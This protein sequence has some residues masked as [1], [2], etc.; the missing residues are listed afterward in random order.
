MN[1]EKIIDLFHA[2]DEQAIQACMDTYGSY[3]RAIVAG[4]LSDHG[5]V[6]ETLADTWL[7]A[8]ESIPPQHPRHLR[9]FLGRIAR[10][11]AVSLWR[12]NNAQSRGGNQIA[13]ALEEL[14]DCVSPG[15]SV[16]AQLDEAALSESITAFLETQPPLQR[17]VF[18]RRYFYL[19]GI[20]SIAHRYG[21][22]PTAVGMMLS[23]TRCKLKKYLIQEG[24]M[25]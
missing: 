3:C 20:A 12:K 17:N 19:E 8:W 14:G 24:Y 6:E 9:L 4:V 11:K 15:A 21:L 7:A 10:N 23:R 25:L 2:R 18:L 5:D 1:D 13:V 22:K 16:E